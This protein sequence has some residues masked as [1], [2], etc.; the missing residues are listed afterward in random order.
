MRTRDRL[1]SDSEAI[2]KAFEQRERSIMCRAKNFWK[3]CSKFGKTSLFNFINENVTPA[4]QTPGIFIGD[5]LLP[6]G[7]QR[8]RHSNCGTKIHPKVAMA[9]LRRELL[10]TARTNIKKGK[11]VLTW[12]DIERVTKWKWKEMTDS[13]NY[14]IPNPDQDNDNQILTTPPNIAAPQDPDIL[15]SDSE[16]EID[17]PF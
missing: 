17:N 13:R 9:C 2:T 6:L 11:D 16:E 12:M 8:Y 15:G 5:V 14:I 3:I 7:K 10:T 1:D 4:Y